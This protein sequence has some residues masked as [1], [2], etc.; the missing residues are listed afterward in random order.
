MCMTPS[1]MPWCNGAELVQYGVS[2]LASC[3]RA[4]VCAPHAVQ[5]TLG[6]DGAIVCDMLDA[7]MA[8]GSG[9]SGRV[10]GRFRTVV[11]AYLPL[12]ATIGT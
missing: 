1:G 12:G 10:A 9:H 2:L 5:P 4:D 8:S 7:A 11:L 3:L 6:T